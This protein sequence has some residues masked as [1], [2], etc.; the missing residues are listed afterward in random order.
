[1]PPR[2]V[3]TATQARMSGSCATRTRGPRPLDAHEREQMHRWLDNW[4]RIPLAA[5]PF[6]EEVLHDQDELPRHEIAIDRHRPTASS[7]RAT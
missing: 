6:E 2:P 1:M 5:L 4:E 7:F 3:E